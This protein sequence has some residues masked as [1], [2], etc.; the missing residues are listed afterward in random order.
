MLTIY[1]TSNF[2]VIAD[3]KF[4]LKALVLSKYS[5]LIRIVDYLALRI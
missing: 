4:H 2:L 5:L 1:R 3:I